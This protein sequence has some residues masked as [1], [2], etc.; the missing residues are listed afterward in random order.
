MSQLAD[1]LQEI[2]TRRGS[3]AI[4][5]YLNQQKGRIIDGLELVSAGKH[6]GSSRWRV[7]HSESTTGSAPHVVTPGKAGRSEACSVVE[8]GSD[9]WPRD[10]VPAP[11]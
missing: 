2:D 6:C 3:Q 4:G 1:V 5:I 10:T 8:V 9:D 7:R 11:Q